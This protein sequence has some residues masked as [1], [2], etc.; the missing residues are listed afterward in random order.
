MKISQTFVYEQKQ[1][2]IDDFNEAE[3]K[4]RKNVLE[5]EKENEGK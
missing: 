2:K 1:I 5:K 4:K 3:E